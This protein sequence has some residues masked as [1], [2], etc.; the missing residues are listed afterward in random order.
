M[1]QFIPDS[2]VTLALVALTT[3]FIIDILVPLG[4]AT[5][6]LYLLCFWLVSNKS[7]P[8]II[9]FAT[10]AALLTIVKLLIFLSPETAYTVLV[11]RVITITV[12]VVVAALASRHRTLLE[13]LNKERKA[14]IRELEEMLEITSH[15]VRKPVAT[16]LGLME[17]LEMEGQLS[18]D[19]L[20]KIIRLLKPNVM[21][22]DVF[23]KELTAFIYNTEAKRNR[24][25]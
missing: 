13:K 12:I 23:T 22:L 14:Y 19:N 20:K 3:V 9:L 7:K 6:V 24:E 1:K 11:N 18:E 15:K 2:Q 5:G 17:L 10:I 8:I 25:E 21:E 16:S 4:V